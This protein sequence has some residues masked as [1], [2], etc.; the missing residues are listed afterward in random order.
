LGNSILQRNPP[1]A[2]IQ[3][4]ISEP[5]YTNYYGIDPST[6]GAIFDSRELNLSTVTTR[7]MD[8]RLQYKREWLG[9]Q[10]ETGIDGTYIFTFD[11]QFTNSAPVT[12]F[13]NT[14]Y[15]PTDLR[16][17]ARE[18]LTRGP[19]SGGLYVN[20]TNAYENT[21]VVPEE[22]V[23]SWLTVDAI[24]TYEFS[25]TSAPLHGGTISVSVVNLT[26]RQPPYA[27]NDNGFP[28]TYDGA[29]ANALGRYVSLRLQKRW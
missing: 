25:P 21:T 28:I 3:Q 9:T 13:R 8:L 20:F 11:D 22:H 24:A 18:I 7:G 14:L 19:L 23:S 16:L 1:A 5:T 4:L 17:R 2:L 29:N 10:F 15:N 26:N 27:A 6:I 12:S